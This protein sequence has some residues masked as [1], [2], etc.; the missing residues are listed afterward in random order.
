MEVADLKF[1]LSAA[2]TGPE[3]RLETL[4]AHHERVSEQGF[5]FLLNN[6]LGNEGQGQSAT[7]RVEAL[8]LITTSPRFSLVHPLIQAWLQAPWGSALRERTEPHFHIGAI[9][10]LYGALWIN[11]KGE[12]GNP[13]WRRQYLPIVSLINAPELRRHI[14]SQGIGHLDRR[15]L[16]EL[17]EGLAQTAM[18]GGDRAGDLVACR[19]V[20]AG[21]LRED[22]KLVKG[23]V[24]SPEKSLREE[25]I[26][27]LGWREKV[28]PTGL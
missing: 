4:C 12:W 24:N 9:I 3:F 17:L 21:H 6:I 27:A 16:A 1:L 18:L 11:K 20:L 5:D 26:K 23:W 2:P 14:L 19:E 25:A 13:A 15:E 10:G 28:R 22:P 7:D 8:H